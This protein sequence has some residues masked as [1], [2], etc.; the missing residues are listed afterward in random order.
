MLIRRCPPV[1]T[2]PIR[3]F[4][5]LILRIELLERRIDVLDVRSLGG[6]IR[7]KF[8][9]FRQPLGERSGALKMTSF[10]CRAQ[11]FA[12][13]LAQNPGDRSATFALPQPF[14]PKPQLFRRR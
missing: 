14:G 12:A 6:F 3:C 11:L 4:K 10:N 7:C 13:L 5:N 2:K 8:A 9:D 1:L